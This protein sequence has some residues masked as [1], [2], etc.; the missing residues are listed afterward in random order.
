MKK[1]F[2]MLTVNKMDCAKWKSIKNCARKL[3][4]ELCAFGKMWN[5]TTCT[6][7]AFPYIFRRWGKSLVISHSK[8]LKH[9]IM[10][11]KK[12]EAPPWF[13]T[14]LPLERN[15]EQQRR[16]TYV[17][18]AHC[19]MRCYAASAAPIWCSA[20]LYLFYTCTNKTPL[21]KIF[22]QSINWFP[23]FPKPFTYQQTQ[24]T[25]CKIVNQWK[26]LK[27]KTIIQS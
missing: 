16:A 18:V 21:A 6:L 10:F 7:A 4:Q 27:K 23:D 8:K 19:Y 14:K 2:L 11:R 17:L 15:M 26:F 25:E 12:E 20:L 9:N 13:H 1:R 22:T 24:S 5:K 3:C